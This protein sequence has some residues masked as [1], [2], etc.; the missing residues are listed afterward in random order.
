MSF[1]FAL[2]RLKLKFLFKLNRRPLLVK[3]CLLTDSICFAFNRNRSG[4]ELTISKYWMKFVLHENFPLNSW[5]ES[6]ARF[7]VYFMYLLRV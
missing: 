6:V 4:M 5:N 2:L 1:V 7:P 3:N